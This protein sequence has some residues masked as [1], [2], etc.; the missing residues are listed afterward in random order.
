MGAG[1]KEKAGNGNNV[2]EGKRQE[3]RIINSSRVMGLK[4]EIANQHGQVAQDQTQHLRPL[5]ISKEK[6][7]IV[8]KQ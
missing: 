3:A 2:S 6:T 5:S 1:H 8:T 7:G 4:E